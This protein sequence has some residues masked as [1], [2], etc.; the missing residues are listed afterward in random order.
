MNG[1]HILVDNRNSGKWSLKITSIKDRKISVEVKIPP[2]ALIGRYNVALVVET[3]SDENSLRLT[4][5]TQTL[6]LDL[7]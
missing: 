2:D 5:D 1:S 6:V 3:E 4:K 7:F